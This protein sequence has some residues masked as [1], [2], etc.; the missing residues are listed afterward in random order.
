MEAESLA[1]EL[2]EARAARSADKQAASSALSTLRGE[3]QASQMA[4][5]AR[6]EELNALANA[7]EAVQGELAGALQS[8]VSVVWGLRQPST[9]SRASAFLPPA[10]SCLAYHHALLC[11]LK[12]LCNACAPCICCFNQF[13]DSCRPKRLAIYHSCSQLTL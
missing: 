11:L 12:P 3:L 6:E 1:G 10:T 2:A 9:G 13:N 5:Q 8:A 7:R 4:E